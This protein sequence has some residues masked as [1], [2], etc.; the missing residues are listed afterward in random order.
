MGKYLKKSNR[1]KSLACLELRVNLWRK[2]RCI[3]EV[4]GKKSFRQ[5]KGRNVIKESYSD[6]EECSG[7]RKHSETFNSEKLR[8]IKERNFQS[9]C[10][11]R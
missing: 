9:S 7:E 5:K 1:K 2:R 4:I 8:D 6:S 11:M 3:V 10:I